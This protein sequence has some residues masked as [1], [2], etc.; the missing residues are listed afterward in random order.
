MA[1]AEEES[2]TNL[3]IASGSSSSGA[4]FLPFHSGFF[5][6]GREGGSSIFKIRASSSTGS[7]AKDSS[8]QT[9]KYA[10]N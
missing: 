6:K 1:A 7:T 5:Y 9:L 10:L 4:A 3:L 2:G 8:P